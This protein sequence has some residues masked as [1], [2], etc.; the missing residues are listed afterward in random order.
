M[1]S[2]ESQSVTR[3]KMSG[4]D[5]VKEVM[6]VMESEMTRRLLGL[7]RPDMRS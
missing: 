6:T 1:K 7:N 5:G 3:I 2:R 4:G